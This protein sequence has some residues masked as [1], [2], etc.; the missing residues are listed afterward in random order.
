MSSLVSCSYDSPVGE[1]SIVADPSS[2]G[3]VALL[4]PNETRVHLGT[5]PE[6]IDRADDPT[7][8][9]TTE[10]L[11]EYF[12]GTRKVF[13]LPLSPQGTDFQCEAWFAL[14][15]IPYGETR[16]YAEQAQAIGRP[17]AVR[18]I[19]AANGRNPISIIVPCHRVIGANGSLTGFGGGLDAK[20]WLLNHERLHQPAPLEDGQLFP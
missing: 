4:W 11:D 15:S 1:L 19:G 6:E 17:K 18:A 13:D 2:G 9:A 10:Q 14:R 3:L 16:T 12:A 7:L 8:R 20:S 5:T